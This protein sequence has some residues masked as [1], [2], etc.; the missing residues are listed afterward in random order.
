MPSAS[1]PALVSV[2]IPSRSEGGRLAALLARLAELQNVEAVVSVPAGD[3]D[4]SVARGLGARVAEGPPGRGAQL[5]RGAAAARGDILLFCHADTALPPGWPDMVRRA[6]QDPL[7]ACGAF[8]LAIDAPGAAY[9]VIETAANIRSRLAGMPYGD[10][11][12]FTTRARYDRAGGFSPLPLMEDVEFVRRMKKTGRV[13]IMETAALTSAR[14]WERDGA[15]WGTLRN[16]ILM[17]LYFAGVS[18]VTLSA[19][20]PPPPPPSSGSGSATHR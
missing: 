10:Q 2:V 6:L 17:A 3:P 16:W 19:W 12:L 8:R 5:A 18:P 13:V 20:Y 4:A 11:A 7:A 14:R 1:A 15:L 9:R